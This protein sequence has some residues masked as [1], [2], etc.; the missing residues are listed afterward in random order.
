[1]PVDKSTDADAYNQ[2]SD[3]QQPKRIRG[4]V[5]SMQ[6]T[7]RLQAAISQAELKENGGK[8]YSTQQISRRAGISISTIG[9]VWACRQGVDQRTLRLLFGA[10]GLKLKDDDIQLLGSETATLRRPADMLNRRQSGGNPM[11]YPRG[12]IPLGSP[13]YIPRPPLE[14][15]ACR[16]IAQPGCI[17]R[18]KAPSGFGKSSLLLRVLAQAEALGYAIASIDL[19]QAGPTTLANPDGFLRWFCGAVA[20]KL[21]KEPDLEDYWNDILGN[22][23]STTMF[24]QEQ[25]LKPNP[26]PLVLNIQEF[27]CLFAYPETAQSFLPLLRSWYEEARHDQ[28]WQKLR[29]VVSYTTD[30]YLPLDIN[31]SPFNVGLPLLLPE[32]TAAQVNTLAELHNL[33]FDEADCQRLMDLVG[34]H[35]TLIRISLYHL[36]QGDLSLDELIETAT[37]PDS[38][39]RAYLQQMLVRLQDGPEQMAQL[40]A[41]VMADAPM[42]LAP[43]LA[44]QLEATG[45]IKLTAA[46]W[47]IG[48]NL[49]RGYL[50]NTLF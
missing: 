17:I 7:Q 30:S 5:L 15:R 26:V 22:F 28:G 2:R 12:P 8:R 9:R 46:G 1:M 43:G 45:L 6:G 42:P 31:Q 13:L 49:Y 35:P 36:S 50:R 37:T 21:G 33:A 11:P 38:V 25:L 18:I 23:L 47:V 16:E 40:K 19:Q 48:A 32:F 27:N 14:E 20:I 44:Y 29:Q 10:F 41:L 24:V 39:F 3:K 4:V 34:G